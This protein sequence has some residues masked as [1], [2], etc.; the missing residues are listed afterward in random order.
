MKKIILCL[1]LVF[2]MMTGLFQLSGCGGDNDE[3][4]SENY[5]Q[6]T[7]L[8][9]EVK[10]N[11]KKLSKKARENMNYKELLED[12]EAVDNRSLPINALPAE[13]NDNE[14]EM[15]YDGE[16][17]YCKTKSGGEVVTYVFYSE[18]GDKKIYSVDW[19]YKMSVSD[20]M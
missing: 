11:V 9:N 12:I 13:K 16:G 19:F 10:Q 2:L 8:E 15:R 20:D 5:I 3:M 4:F 18:I 6:D 1:G 17:Y 14:Y 7:E